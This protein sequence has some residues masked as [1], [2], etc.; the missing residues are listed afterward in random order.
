MV[1][2]RDVYCEYEKGNPVLKGIS[3]NIYD[4]ESIGL[5]GANG[6]GK[7]TLMKAMLGLIPY[8]GDILV[9]GLRVEKSNYQAVRKSLG[10]VLQNSDNQMFMPTVKEDVMFGL[11]NYG[12]S[13]EE[14]EKK[15]DQVLSDLGISHLKERHNHRLSGG[16]KRMAAIAAVLAMDPSHILMDEPCSALD[17]RNRR[18]IINTVL[19]LDRTMI[20][21][22]HD[23]DMILDTCKRTVILSEGKVVAD[24]PSS[25]LLTDRGLLE[26]NGLELPLRYYQSGPAGS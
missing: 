6:A 4:G 16:E 13:S 5:V 10:F 7:S 24:G 20:I 22:S 21:A 8:I 26:S 3:L 25:V 11:L 17:P 15:T 14:A 19:R 9:D 1:E 12:M 18:V 2:L 23:L